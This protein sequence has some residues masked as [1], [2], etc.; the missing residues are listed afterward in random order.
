M[1]S[2]LC[3]HLS[4][5]R[6]SYRYRMGQFLPHWHHYE[7]HVDTLCV[8][9][10]EALKNTAKAL[11]VCGNYDYIWIQ[12]KVFPPPFLWLLSRKA[13]VIF[14]FDDAI[15][16]KQV[17]LTGNQ[18][19]ESL[20]KR[21]WIARTLKSFSI[22]LAGSDALKDH[23]ERYNS[24]VHLVPTPFEAPPQKFNGR[25][26]EKTVTVGWIGVN[27]NLYFLKQIDET[28]GLLAEK[29]PWVRFSLMSGKMPSGMK[30]PWELTP[31]SSESEKQWLA[32]I[33]IG[34]MPLTDDE[35]CRGKCAF[36]LI[37]Y[38]AHGKPVVASNVGAN[39]STITNGVN[40]FLAESAEEWLDALE[41]LVLDEE[42]RKRMGA[43]SRRIHLE[44]FER[45]EVQRKIA[46]LITEHH[47][48]ATAG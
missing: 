47:R 11:A 41:Q 2:I 36:K 37:Q 40:G 7:I 34:I 3:L 22:V 35:W 4:P 31:W 28:L 10:K 29:H 17:M 45:A 21:Q 1:I 48:S 43:E 25:K 16:V 30:T 18:K 8:S 33:D 15:H 5:H 27:A 14:D 44:R 9:G 12:R 38:M 32:R 24:N 39:R 20:L 19:P 23:A 6:P 46:S 42:L 13:K 26:K